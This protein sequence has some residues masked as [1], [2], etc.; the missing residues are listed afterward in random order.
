M[1]PDSHNKSSRGEVIG[2]IPMA[3]QGARIAPLPCSKE[4]YPIGLQSVDGAEGLRP[5]VAGQYLLEKLKLAGSLRCS[6]SC[7]KVNGISLSTLAMALPQGC[8]LLIS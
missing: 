5:K 1:P 4:L 2:L 8:T 7:E 3:G 6:L